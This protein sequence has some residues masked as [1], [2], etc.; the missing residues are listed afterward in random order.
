MPLRNLTCKICSLVTEISHSV[1]VFNCEKVE[2]VNNPSISVKNLM[3]SAISYDEIHSNVEAEL[4]TLKAEKEQLEQ[5]RQEIEQRLEEIN[6]HEEKLRRVFESLADLLAIYPP[7]RISVASGIDE[8]SLIEQS[9][10]QQVKVTSMNQEDKTALSDSDSST[11]EESEALVSAVQAVEGSAVATQELAAD[12]G[13]MNEASPSENSAALSTDTSANKEKILR[14]VADFDPQDFS[15]R[16]PYITTTHPVHFLAGKLLEYFGYGLKLAEIA[17]LIELIGYRHSSRNF[18]DS[19][20][21]ALKNKRKTTG[22]FRFNARKSVWELSHWVVGN[23]NAGNSFKF[24]EVDAAL[25]PPQ[26]ERTKNEKSR[27]LPLRGRTAKQVTGKG[28]GKNGASR[29][30]KVLKSQK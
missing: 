2:D 30:I 19:V 13:N 25:S 28:A 1:V 8:V 21:S 4:Q 9:G 5:R 12:K 20:H 24:E 22:E 15:A 14:Q 29:P 10:T 18:T 6:R 23:Q 11:N 17:R 27:T 7:V 26:Q 3:T 16:F